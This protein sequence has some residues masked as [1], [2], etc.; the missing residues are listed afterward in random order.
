MRDFGE[1]ISQNV[2][3]KIKVLKQHSAVNI[4]CFFTKLQ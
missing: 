4:V 2:M 3:T 1:N